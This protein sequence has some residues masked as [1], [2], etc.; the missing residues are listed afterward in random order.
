MSEPCNQNIFVWIQVKAFTPAAITACYEMFHLCDT[1]P[2]NFAVSKVYAR[3]DMDTDEGGWL[4]IQR[5]TNGTENFN[6]TLEEYEYGFGDLNGEFWY[7]LRNINCLASREPMELRM[8]FG[9][10]G[11]PEIVWT[12]STFNVQGPPYYTLTVTGG[13][14][15]GGFDAMTYST[16]R[17]F[18]TYD[19]DLT[20]N[21]K[22]ASKFGAG[23]W[24]R[25]NSRCHYANPNGLLNSIAGQQSP[26]LLL[27]WST[28]G[29][30]VHYTHTE[31]KVR[32]K[33]C[34]PRANCPEQ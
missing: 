26:N 5:R 6:R 13:K 8:E 23:W 1:R 18:V 33:S 14:G 15:N 28:S 10:G 19:R 32:P 30:Y 25:S 11:E 2:Q 4:V 27:S 16:S 3:C 24:F 9:F 20:G 22:C 31:I 17:H 21:N 7:G 29:G 34:S 12:Y